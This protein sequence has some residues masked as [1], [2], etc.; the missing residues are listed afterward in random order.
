LRVLLINQCFHP[1]VV[2]TAQHGW[3]LA[4]HLVARGHEVTAIASRS[5]Y[6]ERGASLPS[7]ETVDGVRIERV[8]S[9][10]FG[11]RS[12]AAR[13]AD[14]LLFHVAAFI[15]AMSIGR[16]DVSVCFT[17]PPF[18]AVV[19]LALRALR[20]TRCVY[21][22]MD[23]YPDLPVACGVMRRESRVT[24]LFERINRRCLS[25]ADRVVVLGRCMRELVL[26]KGADPSKVELINV[27]SDSREVHP[28]DRAANRYRAEWGAGDRTV[29]MYSGNL[30][31]GHDAQTIEEAIAALAED[32]R[33]LFVLSGGGERKR[34]LVDQ[35]RARGVDR[36]L[37]LPYQPRE[38]LSE[39]LSAADVHLASL[40]AGVEGIMVPSKVYGIMAAAR[41]VVVVAS[42]RS[43]VARAVLESGGGTVVPCGDAPGL[44]DALR[45][46]ADEPARAL[47]EGA[48]G[49][50]AIESRWGAGLALERW[51][52]LLR[53]LGRPA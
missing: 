19:G 7:S 33:F 47:R 12:F 2:A 11:K 51:E 48:L 40:G 25:R 8:G 27:W 3:D 46:Y 9:S 32:E 29:V 21:W 36:L 6:G 4:T 52:W 23:L 30:G 41:P 37:D 10:L 20:G 39:L 5:L 28:V 43:E 31:L 16:Q 35:L 45:A 26:A 15:R 24:R 49:R 14:F 17:T 42:E 50:E 18:I 22:V 13:T 38:R 1:D 34:R 53:S 44:A